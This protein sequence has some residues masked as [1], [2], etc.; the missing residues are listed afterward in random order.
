MSD[1][2]EYECWHC[3]CIISEDEYDV[4]VYDVYD[5]Y[6]CSQCAEEYY[7]HCSRCEDLLLISHMYQ[8][9]SRYLCDNCADATG[10]SGSGNEHIY[11]EEFW[12]N[13]RGRV[14][15]KQ[16]LP[17]EDSVSARYFGVEVELDDETGDVDTYDVVE[18]LEN[19]FKDRRWFALHYP[20]G[21]GS[22][23]NG[24]E[25]ISQPM[26][27]RFHKQHYWKEIFKL[28]TQ[29]GLFG[30]DCRHAGLHI[31]INN[32]AFG[33]EVSE[34]ETNQAK[35]ILLFD[36]LRSDITRFSR[37]T[38]DS[39]DTYAAFYDVSHEFNA[40]MR[41]KR[42]SC[43]MR[44]VNFIHDNT[45]EIRIFRGTANPETFYASLEFCDILVDI[46]TKTPFEEIEN[47]TFA[48]FV[49]LATQKGYIDFLKYTRRRNI[50]PLTTDEGLEALLS[51]IPTNEGALVCV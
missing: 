3:G 19:T 21:D 50:S 33:A 42:N 51:S 37:R 8:R 30:H 45:T 5:R 25:I 31:H 6:V 23:N 35:L 12:R 26:T 1:I 38:L 9:G 49:Y 48:D 4:E 22:L 7:A 15:T 43:K 17:E 46:V 29:N 27:L 41:L 34:R 44:C 18:L 2:V 10:Y 20:K 14:F 40:C 28:V 39:I 47:V 16:S 32:G 13:S 36:V 11:D 24:V